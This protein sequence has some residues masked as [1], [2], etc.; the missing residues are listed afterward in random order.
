MNWKHIGAE[1]ISKGLPLL[2]TVLGG[3]AGGAAG[4]LI[5]SIIG[6]DGENLSPEDVAG[7]ISNPEMV[8]RLRE[9]ESNHALELERIVLQQERQ[10]LGDV[11]DARS[12][13]VENTKATGSRDMNL[14]L[15]AWTVVAGFF[16]LIA[17]LVFQPLP[18]KSPEAIFMLFGALSSGFGAV[19]Q[20]FF[21][22]SKSSQ[23]KTRLLATTNTDGRRS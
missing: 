19:M 22:S 3:P 9:I 21:G 1:L 12:R 10:R 14:Y 11:A 23:E 7:M 20:F 17:L 4:A 2:G 8:V 15:L 16:G 13:D 6:K 18:D 5:G